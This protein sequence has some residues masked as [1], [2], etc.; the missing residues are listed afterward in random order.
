MTHCDMDTRNRFEPDNRFIG[1]IEDGKRYPYGVYTKCEADAR[2]LKKSEIPEIPEIEEI[3]Q[4]LDNKADKSDLEGLQTTLSITNKLNP[5]FI[6]YNGEYAK[7]SNTEKASWN[8]KIAYA[9]SG[10]TKSGTTINHSN[11]VTAKTVPAFSQ[12]SYDAQGHITGA[13][14]ATSAQLEALNSG[15]TSTKI[16]AI[17]G[18]VAVT[19]SLQAQIDQIEISS[20]AESVVAPEVAAARVGTDGTEYTTLKNRLDAENTAYTQMVS[21]FTE[22]LEEL[23]NKVISQTE[24]LYVPDYTEKENG[25]LAT[26]AATTLTPSDSYFT[27]KV[28]VKENTTYTITHH[29]HWGGFFDASGTKVGYFGASS[30]DF[31]DYEVTTPADTAYMWCVVPSSENL[32]DFMVVEGTTMPAE[33]VKG[34]ITLNS[35]VKITQSA[36]LFNLSHSQLISFDITTK[37]IVI[38]LCSIIYGNKGK[39]FT[40]QTIDLTEVETQNSSWAL[41]Y[42]YNENRVIP[43]TWKGPFDYPVV[44]VVYAN[45]IYVNGVSDAQIQ[46]YDNG[47]VISKS[48]NITPIIN[49][50][51]TQAVDFDITAKTIHIPKSSIIYGRTG[52]SFSEQTIDLTETETQNSSWALLY[53]YDQKE[54]KASFWK[55]PFN[56]PV[57]GVV[58]GNKIFMNGLLESQIQYY[59]NGEP[60]PAKVQQT[61][62]LLN[63]TEKQQVSFDTENK[64]LTIP[65]CSVLYGAIGKAFPSISIDLTETETQNS[66]WALMYNYTANTIEPAMWKG[67]FNYPLIGIVYSKKLYLNGVFESQIKNFDSTVHFFGDSITAGVH[68]TDAFHMFW[69]KWGKFRCKNYGIG[70]TG[71]K[72][73]YSGS[74]L[75]GNGV[76]GIGSMTTQT[77]NNTILDVMQSVGTFSRCVIFGGTND[78]GNSEN[79]DAFRA[80]VQNTLDYA[81]DQTPYILVVTPIMRENFKTRVNNVGK[82]LVD[83]SNVIIEECENRGIAYVDGMSVSLNPDNA[84]YKSTFIPDGL[85]P[86]ATGHTM[87]ARK[88]YSDFLA[89]MA[90]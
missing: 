29:R 57:V 54:I 49:L 20:S 13:T 16:A 51:H 2:F 32:S 27:L 50:S 37:V 61:V 26:S 38:P 68:T 12:I 34:N 11:A 82:K 75:A 30:E 84:S 62:P 35:Y 60:V 41:L 1:D 79:I 53:D 33:V 47:T 18:M 78:F 44:G 77:G 19:E 86:N 17:D 42:D 3:E 23:E 6:S 80:A 40:E 39:G 74:A 70:T 9:G 76:E 58:Y 7:V 63:L 89:A 66:S 73:A 83:Y 71:Y 4:E 24:N 8:E 87:L 31:Y 90:K 43:A 28:R 5:E 36:P 85:H 59:D 21:G 46:Y 67:P 45:K 22:N 88:L 10:L 25:Y 55:G 56:Y 14:D 15:A 52:N 65:Q 69:A 81:L 48:T 72:R 64:I